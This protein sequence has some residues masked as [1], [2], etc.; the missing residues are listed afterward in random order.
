MLS[1][2]VGPH[3]VAT[4]AFPCHLLASDGIVIPSLGSASPHK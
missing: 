3:T 4:I 1:F 2:Q